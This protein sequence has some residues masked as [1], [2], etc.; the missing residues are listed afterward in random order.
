MDVLKIMIVILVL[1]MSLGAVC[2]ADNVDDVVISDDGQDNLQIAHDEIYTA[3]ESSFTDLEGEIK[4]AGMVLELTKD[5][6][7]NNETDNE[8]GINISRDNFVLNGGGHTLDGDFQSRI[9]VISGNNVTISNLNFI[10]GNRSEKSGG[11]IF[12]L[13]SLTLNNVNFYNNAALR[14]GAVFVGGNLTINDA[15]FADNKAEDGGAIIIRGETTIN[16][17]IFNNNQGSTGGAIYLNDETTIT[18]SVFNANMAENGGAIAVLSQAEIKNSTFNSNIAE[19][20]GGAISIT[21]TTT[22]TNSVF[23][24]NKAQKGGAVKI[25]MDTN[26]SNT[27]FSN[28]WAN[29]TGGAVFIAT[30]N[31]T[32]TNVTFSNNTAGSFGG[33]I[34]NTA[35]HTS[36]NDKFINNR[37]ES[38]EAIY[39]EENEDF[40]LSNGTFISDEILGWGL[41]YLSSGCALLDNTTFSNIK[42]NYSTV[43]YGDNS[44]LGVFNCDFINLTAKKTAGAIGFKNFN[45]TSLL[46]INDTFVN[47][48]SEKD[49]GAIFVDV[50]G[51][52]LPY[53]GKVMI[54]NSQFTNCASEFGGA[55][56]QLSGNLVMT[57][58]TFTSNNAAYNGGALYLSFVTADITCSTFNSNAVRLY[59][60]YTTYGGGIYADFVTLNLFDCIFTNNIAEVGNGIYL[61]DSN[62]NIADTTFFNNSNAIYSDFPIRYRLTDNKY[63]NDNISLNNTFFETVIS[64]TGIELESI[65]NTI[66]V[67]DLPSKFD[68]RD[69]GWAS[70]VKDQG[71]MGA[72][73]TFGPTGA[74]ESALLKATGLK[75]DFSEN[76]MQNTMLKYSKYGYSTFP[77]SGTNTFAASYLV[78]WLGAFPKD[79]DSYDELGKLSP[80]LRSDEC[81]HVQDIMFI[82]NDNIS[83]VKSAILAFGSLDANIY[84]QSSFNEENPYY[85]PKTYSQY[86]NVTTKPNHEISVVGWDDN[87]SKNNFYLQPEGDG[88]WICKNSWGTEWGDNGYFYVSYYDKTFCISNTT[89]NEFMAIL[90]ENTEVYDTNYQH[91]IT[92]YGEFY[93]KTDTYANKFTALGNEEIAAVGTFFES[94]DINYTVSIYVN[95]K[96]RLTQNGTSPFLG[97]HTIKLDEYIPIKKGDEFYVQ[98]TSKSVPFIDYDD[99]RVHYDENMTFIYENDTWHDFLNLR[100]VAFIKAYT[101]DL[102]IYTD[103]LVKVYKNASDFVANIGVANKT[104]TFEINGKNYTRVSDENGTAVMAINLNPGNYT[105]KTTFN[106]TTV[107]NNITVLPTLMA[108]NLVKYYRNASQFYISLID[109]KGKPVVGK[110]I[111]MNING[112][113]Y[114]RTTDVNGTAKLNI[115]LLPGEYVLTAIDPLTGLMMSY[116]ITVLPTLIAADLE[117]KYKDGST[118]NATVLDGQGKP[119]AKAKV[120]FNVNGV[121]YTRNTNS[122][123]IAQLNINLMAGKYIITSAYDGMAIANTITIKD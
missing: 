116:N 29:T 77:E 68:L 103:N 54:I 16:N 47:V 115:N 1:I 72:C 2:A 13:G 12:V 107:E 102:D 17:A 86:C 3:G 23:N 85:Y 106:S 38:G 94:E 25:D 37:A 39:C 89:D 118:F 21:S 6:T 8:I 34:V 83:D 11:A 35:N 119:L 51:S 84:A 33:A 30:N 20:S 24:K 105:I 52:S 26:I 93:N 32:T 100:K 10:N 80:V 40:T 112:V 71:R 108:E 111:T 91:A 66:N 53:H 61:L 58:T 4:N 19:E 57:N 50:V 7:F 67:T 117:M 70:P 121:F 82:P 78:S 46:L 60:D 88:A 101:K 87:F 96:L 81:V 74:L 44:T 92:W 98:I 45:S 42:S 90:F 63:N 95:N 64:Q 114:N 36:K 120:T 41:I 27:I 22:I 113:F 73:W 104:V 123:G 9:F 99:T 49:G 5:Y 97:F 55:Y 18:D 122:E 76:N 31:L 43:V 65:N 110:N 75:A 69:W 28:N 62:F 48:G 56:V 59:D 79:Y 109:G 15:L 14:G